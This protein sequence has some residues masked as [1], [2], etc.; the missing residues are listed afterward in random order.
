MAKLYITHKFLDLFLGVVLVE[1]ALFF[2]YMVIAANETAPFIFRWVAL[3]GAVFC[4]GGA[5]MS[6][7]TM[8][9]SREREEAARKPKTTTP[10]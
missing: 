5:Y 3:H 9:G 10:A 2:I 8:S 7:F 4:F 6:L 1:M